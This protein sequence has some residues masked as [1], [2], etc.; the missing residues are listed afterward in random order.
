MNTAKGGQNFAVL[1]PDTNSIVHIS[2]SNLEAIY[3]NHML[4]HTLNSSVTVTKLPQKYY[5]QKYYPQK[6]YP[7]KYYPQKYYPHLRKHHHH[8]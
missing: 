8:P 7:Q 2:N 6:Y 3:S 1:V 4:I 5:P